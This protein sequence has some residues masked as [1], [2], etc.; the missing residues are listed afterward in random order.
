MQKYVGIWKAVYGIWMYV[1]VF[2][3]F[4]MVLIIWLGWIK[5]RIF[6]LLFEFIVKIKID[7][8]LEV[9]VYIIALAISIVFVCKIGW[10]LSSNI[11]W[12]VNDWVCCFC[13]SS[14]ILRRWRLPRYSRTS[15]WISGQLSWKVTAVLEGKL[16]SRR[17]EFQRNFI[18]I[19][20]VVSVGWLIECSSCSGKKV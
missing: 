20:P 16:Q 17:S 14:V 19:S 6:E 12:T 1:I 5:W 13:A 11:W 3:R 8:S 15:I 7:L 18:G 2:G 4:V 9:L 10:K